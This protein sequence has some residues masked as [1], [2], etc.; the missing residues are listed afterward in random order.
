MPQGHEG[1]VFGHEGVLATF[2][3]SA[4]PTPP[5]LWR[6]ASSTTCLN[7]PLAEVVAAIHPV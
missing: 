2:G 7:N 6:E 4:R 1:G 5:G 3:I